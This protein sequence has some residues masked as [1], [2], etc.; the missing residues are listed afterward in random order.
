MNFV[1]ITNSMNHN[2]I[3]DEFWMR[4]LPPIHGIQN[5]YSTIDTCDEP[6]QG[7]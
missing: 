3:G 7:T 4:I 6:G 1:N 5:K 2:Q